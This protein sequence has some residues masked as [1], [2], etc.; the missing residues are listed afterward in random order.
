MGQS[1]PRFTVDYSVTFFRARVTHCRV[2]SSHIEHHFNDTGHKAL[3]PV[4]QSVYANAQRR[5]AL[6][7]R[8]GLS[9]LR[10]LPTLS[11]P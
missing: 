10:P 3:C 9:G 8:V 1:T 5:Y 4:S 6:V 2:H 11:A 7:S